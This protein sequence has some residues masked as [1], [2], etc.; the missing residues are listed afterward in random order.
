MDE[1]LAASRSPEISSG[2]PSQYAR[3]RCRG[4]G[5]S[6]T[7]LTAFPSKLPE[8]LELVV[9][10]G[11]VDL[12]ALLLY[13]YEN[14]SFRIPEDREGELLIIDVRFGSPL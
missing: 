6:L 5:A 9:V 10:G 12:S 1:V 8:F 7:F 13:T 14:G 4:G 3:L 2:S 11:R